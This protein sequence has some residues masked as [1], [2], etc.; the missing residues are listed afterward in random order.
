M[1]I[2]FF[3][4][5][6]AGVL[7]LSS[8][9]YAEEAVEYRLPPGIYPLSQ[10]I[11][12]HLDPNV[13][14]Y[15]GSTTIKI[16]VDETADRLGIY[17][18]G[19]TMNRI[20]L[21]GPDVERELAATIGE[22][23]IN[24]L[25]DG[26]P[27]APGDYEL[28]IQFGA[29]YATDSLGMH[30]VRF[31]DNDYVFTQFENMYARRAFPVFD[32]PAFKIPFQVAIN[33]PSGMTVI[34]NAPV[35]SQSESDGWQRVE[36]LS[37]PPIPSYLI[38]YGVGPLDSAPITGL[39]VPGRIYTPKGRAGEV[40]F[41]AR[42]TPAILKAL[43]SYFGIDYPYRKL[44][45]LAVPEFAF[46]AMENPG[47]VTF[48]T[49]YLMV[50]DTPT[51]VEAA[52][53]LSVIAHELAH[54]WYGNLVTMRWW[55]DLWLNES[56][57]SWMAEKVMESLYPEYE[58]DLSLPQSY[59]F[60]VDELS[61][62][63]PV[64]R[65]VRSED[66]A[67]EDLGLAYSKG[68]T[69]LRMLESY[70]G[71]EAFQA[72]VRDYMKRFSR[73]NA[74]EHDL[75]SVV[76]E[77]ADADIG[78]IAAR[79]LNQPGFPLVTVDGRGNVSQS[80]YHRL[81]REMPAQQWL[82]PLSVKYKHDG[83]IKQTFTLLDKP[84]GMLDIPADV[85]WVFPDA[86]ANGYYRWNTDPAQ[87]QRLLQDMSALSNREKI[88]LLDNS[89]AL[90]NAGQLSLADYMMVLDKAL[91][92]PHPL[93]LRPALN[94][95]S[96]IAED[97]FGPANA[98]AFSRFVD[99]TLEGR[100]EQ[101]GLEP[102]AEESETIAQLRPTLVVVQGLYGSDEALRKQVVAVADKYLADSK[103]VPSDLG[104]AALGIKA[105]FG[106]R[107]E[108]DAFRKA[109]KNASEVSLKTNVLSSIR[110]TDPEI[111]KDHLD[112]SLSD[113]VPAGEASWGLYMASYVLDDYGILF[114]WLDENLDAL[115]RKLPPVR[116]PAL[117]RATASR[118]NQGNLE[119]LVAFYEPRDDIYKP[120]LAKSVESMENC[121]AR[122][123][124]E[125]AALEQF[126]ERYTP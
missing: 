79:Y 77:H 105:Q 88:A 68:E 51:G 97:F 63:K 66:E 38:A 40:G 75:W 93:V 11:E 80:R 120:Y 64:R 36:F 91:A 90:L 6:L 23:N 52:T 19:L 123:Q 67:F 76:A 69:I 48:R 125:G 87:F 3:A 114:E 10:S 30:R 111:I 83:V 12:L 119:G 124:R 18:L 56:F 26:K 115:V 54:Q 14:D 70:S 16:R 39:S 43:E 24:W 94:A 117:P 35:A 86:G 108:Y 122:K 103:S 101:I 25:A 15:T 126:L 20:V 102:R 57:A 60:P 72:A 107:P 44:D 61:T 34:G 73:S 32:E 113:E 100:L 22:W 84:T 50:G 21:K 82:I 13:A 89:E 81:G 29:P 28:Q 109:Y 46:G 112:W 55:D 78:A 9:V 106:G 92:D 8:A 110:F 33:A 1:K 41:A 95:L 17:Q 116:V 58:T 27:V 96:G 74:T 98:E 59:A 85:E 47:L 65:P 53:V 104:K 99:E 62:A 7:V 49:D 71:P 31:E 121:I 118:C 4:A 45:F 5:V 2:R 42:E 37:T